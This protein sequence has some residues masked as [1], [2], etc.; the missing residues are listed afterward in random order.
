MKKKL[1]VTL[2]AL[3]FLCAYTLNFHENIKIAETTNNRNLQY[4]TW[5]EITKHTNLFDNVKTRDF[6]IARNQNDA[7]EYNAATFYKYTKKRLAYFY[8]TSTI[9]PEIAACSQLD[10]CLLPNPKPISITKLGTLNRIDNPT[11]SDAK[12]DWVVNNIFSPEINLSSV[13]ATDLV[14]LTQ[15]MIFVYVAKFDEK[16]ENAFIDTSTFRSFLIAKSGN[17]ISPKFG[18]VCLLKSKLNTANFDSAYSI[19]EWVIPGQKSSEKQ[20]QS[21]LINYVDANVGTC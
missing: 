20:K 3:M 6:L 19:T 18:E 21:S 9:Y 11:L 17:I 14:N 1:F 5:S 2:I 16:S 7:Y 12:S 13:W 15:D 10:K 4:K 8:N